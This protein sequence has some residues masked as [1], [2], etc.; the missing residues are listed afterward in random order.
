MMKKLFYILAAFTGLVATAQADESSV[1]L[2]GGCF[3]CMEKPFDKT[4]GVLDVT[5]GYTGGSA[6]RANYKAVSA[7]KTNHYEAIQVKYDPDKITYAELLKV[8]WPQVDPFD[9]KGQFCDKGTQYRAAIFHMNNQERDIALASKAEVE[10]QLAQPVVTA[11]LPRQPFYPAE[12][13]HQD[14]YKKNPLR[15]TF[16]RT[17]CGRDRRLQQVWGDITKH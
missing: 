5:V 10:K 7:D 13:Y 3:W 4:E 8:F 15:Y 16:Y 1:V 12:D 2:A 6:E 11:I 9:D 17:R 14:Y